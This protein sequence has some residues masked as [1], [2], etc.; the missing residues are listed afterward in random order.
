VSIWT[1]TPHGVSASVSAPAAVWLGRDPVLEAPPHTPYDRETS[2]HCCCRVGCTTE[3]F[4][5]LG[6]TQCGLTLRVDESIDITSSSIQAHRH[7]GIRVFMTPLSA[8]FRGFCTGM[9]VIARQHAATSCP[10]QR[11]NKVCKPLTRYRPDKTSP[12][13]ACTPRRNTDKRATAE[14]Y[15]EQYHDARV[16]YLGKLRLSAWQ[17][18]VS[19]ALVARD[20]RIYSA[21]RRCS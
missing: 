16:G 14:C 11:N 12:Y 15:S 7:Q 19:A 8:A 17:S 13:L 18:F 3:C 4:G 10:H 20:R 2:L 9:P 5:Y 21:S 1:L 6:A